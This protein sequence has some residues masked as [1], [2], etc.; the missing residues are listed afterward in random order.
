MKDRLFSRAVTK[1]TLLYTAILTIICISFSIAFYTAANQELNRPISIYLD[2]FSR[3]SGQFSF[4]IDFQAL[5]RQRDDKMRANLITLLVI[6]DASVILVGACASYFFARWTLQPIQ[7]MTEQQANFITGASHE[8]RTPLTA[9]AMENAVA[10][11][12]PSLSKTDLA[13]V[14]KSNLEETHKLQ[15]L[16]DRL[17][18]LS[19]DE[20]LELSTINLAP[21][22]ELA[23]NNLSTTAK[24]KQITIKNHVKLT[25][26]TSN[27]AALTNI[28][29][30]LLENAIKYSPPKSTITISFKD[31]KLS[32]RDQ[33]PG[34]SDADLPHIFD[35]F[36]RAEQSR[37]NHGYG[38]GLPL[39][40]QLAEQL[41]LKITATNNQTTGTTFTLEPL[42]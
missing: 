22:I 28:L 19:Q 6:I 21:A 35:R 14:L 23:I 38:L 30:I 10:L 11:R 33:G 9:I 31:S 12:D 40:R 26:V 36:Y 15:N 39:A 41:H 5:I 1:L 16:T 34:I 7:K 8:L 3:I 18:K 4:D 2:D 37:T 25:T 13:N 24:N 32:V 29:T 17:L 42:I 27:T 20:P